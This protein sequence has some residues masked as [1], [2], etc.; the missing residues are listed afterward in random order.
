V[1]G[2]GAATLFSPS[3][4]TVSEMPMILDADLRDCSWN[5]EPF[6]RVTVTCLA[7]ALAFQLLAANPWTI[8]DAKLHTVDFIGNGT[9]SHIKQ[10]TNALLLVRPV[11]LSIGEPHRGEKVELFPTSAGSV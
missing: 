7:F 2:D 5:Q 8:T 10:G 6:V 4:S 1:C 9:S 11:W 3:A